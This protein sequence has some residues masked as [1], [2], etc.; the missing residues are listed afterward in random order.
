M[1]AEQIASLRMKAGMTQREL[2]EKLHIG[3][4]AIGMYEQGRREPSVEMLIQIAEI[5]GVSLDFLITGKEFSEPI[6]GE[7]EEIIQ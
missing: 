1:L 5:F 4:S 6:T 7:Q 3:P 2:A